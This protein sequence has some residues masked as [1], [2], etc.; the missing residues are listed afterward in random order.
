[1]LVLVVVIVDMLSDSIVKLV[2]V[3]GGAVTVC[4]SVAVDWIVSVIV[5]GELLPEG[6]PGERTLLGTIVVGIVATGL[7]NTEVVCTASDAPLLGEYPLSQ[8]VVPDSTA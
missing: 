5:L 6:E 2:E 1:M 3:N 4:V 8:L 7:T